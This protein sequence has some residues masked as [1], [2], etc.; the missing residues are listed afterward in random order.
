MSAS[1]SSVEVDAAMDGW[2][3]S[4]AVRFPLRAAMLRRLA[5]NQWWRTAI[6]R[7]VCRA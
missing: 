2:I 3:D 1:A 6:V 5:R 7:A 4:V